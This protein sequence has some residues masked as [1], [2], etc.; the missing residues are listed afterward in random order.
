MS[1]RRTC[2]VGFEISF[3]TVSKAEAAITSFHVTGEG[4]KLVQTTGGG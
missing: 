1:E 2:E 4:I 3:L